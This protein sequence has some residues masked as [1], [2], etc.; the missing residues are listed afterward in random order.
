MGGGGGGRMGEI[1]RQRQSQRQTDGNTT[2]EEV[3]HGAIKRQVPSQSV[4]PADYGH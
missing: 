4:P 3:K 2:V 1:D